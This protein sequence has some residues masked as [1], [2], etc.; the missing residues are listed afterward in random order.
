M[1]IGSEEQKGHDLAKETHALF[2][3]SSLKEQF[4]GNIEGRDINR[5]ACDV[6]VTDGFVGNVVLKVCEGVFEFTMKMVAKE[7]VGTLTTERQKAQKALEAMIDHY[8]YSSQ[9]GAPLLGIDGICIICHGSSGE[10]AIK[11]ALGVA[12]RYARVKLNELIVKELESSPPVAS[13]DEY[14]KRFAG[15]SDEDL[16][17]ER[18]LL[19]ERNPDGQSRLLVSRS[20]CADH[21]H[22][23]STV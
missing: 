18:A 17:R 19:P 16:A 1:N 3:A 21:R 11:N 15:S 12:A 4:I 2:N 6:V 9:G 23:S 7:I 14:G 20:R 5:G 8:D 22:G 10:R 13:D